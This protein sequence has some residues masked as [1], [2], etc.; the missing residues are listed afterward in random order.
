[1]A[2]LSWQCSV[3]TVVAAFTMSCSPSGYAG[4]VTNPAGDDCVV[5]L[6]GLARSSWSLNDMAESVADDGY[7]AVNIDYPSRSDVVE[8]LAMQAIP[9]GLAQCRQQGSET[10]HFV[11]HSMGGILLRYYLSDEDIP[12]LGRVV[13]LSPPNKGSE[14][15]DNL[16]DFWFFKWQNGPAGQQ[17][18]T[19]PDSLPK[20]LGPATFP[21]GIITGDDPAF[22]DFWASDMIPGP[23]D[24]KVSVK[25]AKLEGMTDFLVL[26]VS[27]T[28]IMGDE[29]VISQTLHFLR[30]ETFSH[31]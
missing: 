31:P 18:C 27:H 13:M 2:F 4:T 23:D 21:L 25:N 1:M 15:V 17:L 5:L 3:L 29:E 14:V 16:R 6:H 10:I 9:E 11:T 24:G 7:I 22:Y 28:F 12:E 20:S 19:G 26:P 8:N 30:H